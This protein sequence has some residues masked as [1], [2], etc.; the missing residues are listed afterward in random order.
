MTGIAPYKPLEAASQRRW[1]R[2]VRGAEKCGA[3][4]EFDGECT[5][6]QQIGNSSREQ[7][8]RRTLCQYETDVCG[9]F[10]NGPRLRPAFV[11]QV[12]GQAM[13][14]E[15]SARAL[16]AYSKPLA[17]PRPLFDADV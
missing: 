13:E 7:S 10:W 9:S 3:D 2:A 16:T 5:N 1:N 6:P 17:A 11:A 14:T 12:L 15:R 8:E 4:L